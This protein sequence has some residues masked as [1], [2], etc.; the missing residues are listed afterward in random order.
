MLER[1]RAMGGAFLGGVVLHQMGYEFGRC[2]LCKKPG[3]YRR[4][5][6]FWEKKRRRCGAPVNPWEP[7]FCIEAGKV[8]K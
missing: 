8:P 4:G 7:A 1:T 2:G 5:A 3:L 6:F